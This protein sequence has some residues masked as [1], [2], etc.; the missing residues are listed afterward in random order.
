MAHRQERACVQ[1]ADAV[2]LNTHRGLEEFRS[3]YHWLPASK[4]SV[5]TNGYDPEQNAKIDGL[6]A[7]G[8]RQDTTDVIRLCHPGVLY[9]RRDPD[10]IFGAMRQVLDA[11]HNVLFEQIGYVDPRIPLLE[12]ARH[13][14]LQDHVIVRPV[15]EHATVL[16][17]MADS[18]VLVV[19]QP[20]TPLQVPSK[21]YEML[22]FRKPI[23]AIAADGETA[24]IVTRY[25][26]GPV[27]PPGS[28]DQL[29]SAIL[30]ATER[31]AYGDDSVKAAALQAFDGKR[32][33]GELAELLDRLAWQGA[34]DG[35]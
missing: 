5:I 29:A 19:L 11:G 25:S 4:F 9:L 33:T 31:R 17:H 22:A 14:G 35:L 12:S 15:T 30:Q 27:V 32:L 28:V 24:D 6:L 13:Y 18:D 7:R 1:H 8:E 20:D 2:V 10:A 3:Y 34:S 21:L 23:L 16:Q 26:L